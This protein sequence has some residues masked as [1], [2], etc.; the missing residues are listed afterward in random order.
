MLVMGV[1]QFPIQDDS[2]V[3]AGLSPIA[4][5]KLASADTEF[6]GPHPDDPDLDLAVGNVLNRL[7]S[8]FHQPRLSISTSAE[9]HDLTCFVMHRLLLLPPVSAS[10]PRRQ[11]AS[12]CLRYSLALYMLIIH[13]ATYYSHENL[14]RSLAVQLKGHLAALAQADHPH[15]GFEIW[16][17][18]VG[19]VATVGTGEHGWFRS[20]ALAAALHLELH[21]W[22]DVLVHLEGVLW[23]RARP[24]VEG[25]FRQT[26]KEALAAL[27]T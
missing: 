16:F 2:G 6:S 19:M 7:R 9:L 13:G 23:T 1:P 17:L 27:A 25:S 4:Q 8:I 12:E 14:A 10:S 11:A 18:S 3:G 20:R 22:E 15:D 21:T 5:W 26:W 24:H